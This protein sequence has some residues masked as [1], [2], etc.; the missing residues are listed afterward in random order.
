MAGKPNAATRTRSHHRRI[1]VAAG[2][3]TPPTHS[4]TDASVC[5]VTT[6]QAKDLL[7]HMEDVVSDLPLEVIQGSRIVEVRH[8]LANKGRFVEHVVQ[9]LRQ[10]G[11]LFVAAQS[12]RA[13]RTSRVRYILRPF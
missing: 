5:C 3:R 7:V 9:S 6:W 12:D 11:K 2:T 8:H 10:Q 4:V 13:S 1:E